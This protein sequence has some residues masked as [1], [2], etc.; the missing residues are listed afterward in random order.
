MADSS[1]FGAQSVTGTLITSSILPRIRT[2]PVLGLHRGIAGK[3]GPVL[4]IF[5][6]RVLY[7][8]FQNRSSQSFAV[9][10]DRLEHAG[11]GVLYAYIAG[12]VLL[13]GG[14]DVSVIVIDDRMIPGIQG[15][16][17]RASW[18]NGRQRAAEETAVFRLPPGVDNGGLAF[19]DF[20]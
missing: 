11:P 14:I 10:P 19:A 8:T 15:P 4:P 3:V 17:C 9:S 1:L 5:A 12:L 7:S 20:L 2:I 18:F 13:P 16:R 6:F